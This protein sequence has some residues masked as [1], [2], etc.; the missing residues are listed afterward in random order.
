MSVRWLLRAFVP[1]K[2]RAK[3]R[4]WIY[5]EAMKYKAP[6]MI[7]GF[8]D[9][10][11]AWRPRTRISDTVFFYHPERIE[12]DDN[13]FIWHYTILDG[14]GGIK[15]GEGAQ[16]GAWVGIFTHSSHIA[17]RI[18][19]NHY[20]EVPETEKKGYPI[21]PIIIGRYVFVGAGS[22]ILPGISVG[23]GALIAAGAIV[24]KDVANFEVVSGNPAEVVGNTKEIDEKYLEDPQIFKW[25]TEWQN[26]Q[27]TS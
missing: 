13:V 15:I 5:R 19:G 9:S 7:W 10:T 12:I 8:K 14:T 17:I 16:I 3:I 6:K 22:K 23:D 2:A 11:G 24:T 25:Y 26:S 27:T 4:S 1:N 21:A 20:Q 18:Y